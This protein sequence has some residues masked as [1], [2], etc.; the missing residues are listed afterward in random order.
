MV[1]G[2]GGRAKDTLDGLGTGEQVITHT[3]P[4]LNPFHNDNVL[5]IPQSLEPWEHDVSILLRLPG[6]IG[7]G[8]LS[9]T[10][11]LVRAMIAAN[12]VGDPLAL[13]VP[14]TPVVPEIPGL[15]GPAPDV[16]Q[17]IGDADQKVG[18]S[19]GEDFF[20]TLNQLRITILKTGN[21]FLT[22]VS[23]AKNQLE[24][25]LT[26]PGSGAVVLLNIVNSLL[27]CQDF[28]PGLFVA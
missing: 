20:Q 17:R 6:N 13:V 21:T 22:F 1:K 25:T 16:V 3:Q 19:G 24:L 5:T 4:G 9:I 8:N 14:L 27:R 26:I 23:R 12:Q 18:I 2:V 7:P 10:E 11:H 28:Q 15:L